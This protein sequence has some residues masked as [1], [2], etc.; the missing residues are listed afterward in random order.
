MGEKKNEY[1]LRRMGCVMQKKPFRDGQPGAYA[2]VMQKK[3]FRD[4]Q[5]GAYA[6][7]VQFRK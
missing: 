5:P 3:Y 4:G 1:F 7:T 2:C 6:C